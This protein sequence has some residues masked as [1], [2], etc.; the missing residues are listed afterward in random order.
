MSEPYLLSFKPQG[1]FY[2]GSSQSWDEGFHAVSRRFP[3]QMTVLGCLRF[4]L[5]KKKGWLSSGTEDGRL[6]PNFEKY[7]NDI[8]GLTGNVSG[9][10]LKPSD[11][12]LGILA[13]LSPVF[14][15]EWKNGRIADFLLQAPAD[16]VWADQAQ[17]SIRIIDYKKTNGCSYCIRPQEAALL[18]RDY[19]NKIPPLEY[20]GGREFWEAYINGG[21]SLPFHPDLTAD[22]L[23][24]PESQFGIARQ[25]RK[26][27]EGMFYRKDHYRLRRD[28]SLGVIVHFDCA[29]GKPEDLLPNGEIVFLGGEQSKFTLKVSPVEGEAEERINQHPVV[30]DFIPDADGYSFP[31]AGVK[32]K[33]AAL[34]PL[35]ELPPA[36]NLEFAI[37]PGLETV[38]MIG[39]KKMIKSDAYSMIPVGSVFYPAQGYSYKS[40]NSY[41]TKIGYNRAVHAQRGA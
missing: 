15:V 6:R 17:K 1:P 40:S 11:D 38:R 14:L 19:N 32:V 31:N 20:Y 35:L 16:V 8:K 23:F 21:K 4:N 28:Y 29:Q 10:S 24:I 33:L 26:S 12:N 27:I 5:L 34:S 3:T 2:F 30:K 18:F 25:E 22:S 9:D 41:A 7:E 36:N 37:I 39:G 13:R